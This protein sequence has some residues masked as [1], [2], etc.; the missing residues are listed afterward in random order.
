MRSKFAKALLFSMGWIAIAWIGI[1]A[2]ANRWLGESSLLRFDPAV[3]TDY[4]C[5]FVEGHSAPSFSVPWLAK[6]TPSEYLRLRYTPHAD[7]QPYGIMFIDPKTLTYEAHAGFASG[8]TRLSGKLDSPSIIRDWMRSQPHSAEAIS[9]ERDAQEIL[10]AI[11]VLSHRDLEEFTRPFGDQPSQ[12]RIGHR[13]TPDR[14]HPSWSSTFLVL[15][16]IWLGVFG[17]KTKA[18]VAIQSIPE[19]PQRIES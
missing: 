19:V 10:D 18:A 17:R 15:I 16:C 6:G 12:F 8:P 1:P 13:S 14:N 7:K 4:N 9:H 3:S 2:V 5:I 11:L